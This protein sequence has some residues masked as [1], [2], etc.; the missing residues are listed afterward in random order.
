[1]LLTGWDA[2]WLGLLVMGVLTLNLVGLA[3]G[4]AI[5]A[6]KRNTRHP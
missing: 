3:I 6:L 4:S 5:C 1:M 2:E